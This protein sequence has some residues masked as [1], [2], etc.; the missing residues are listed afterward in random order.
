MARSL[1]IAAYL[2]NLGATEQQAT[3]PE[4]APRPEGHIIW[5][6]CCDPDQLTAVETLARKLTV[7][8]D[9][10]H[11]MVT[12]TSW[13]PVYADRAIPEP[14]GKA[15]IADFIAH[16]QPTMCVWVK[17]Q[18]DVNLMAGIQTS[19]LRCMLVDATAEGLEGVSGGWVPGTMRTLLTQFEA[20][21]TVDQAAADKLVRAGAPEQAI[22]VAGA[23]EDCAP[24]MPYIESER[25]ELSQA[26]GT[27]PVW[28]AASV[29]LSEWDDLCTAQNIASLRAHRLLLIIVPED[30]SDAAKMAEKMREFGFK[31][32]L[33]SEE[34]DPQEVTQIYIVDTDEELGLWY[35][36][37]PLTYVGG[38]L[39]GKNCRD[40]FE[41]AVLG[42]AVV[43]GPNV[44]AYQRHA[45]RLNAADAS[46][47]I[48]TGAELGPAI[49]ALMSADK[50][51]QLAHKAW[52]VTSRG[53]NV[54]NRIAA[55][56]Q[57]R[58]EELVH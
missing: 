34:Y 53:A 14:H 55:F 27:R 47:L 49:E 48:R 51:A 28:L 35:R 33:R 40:P 5:A 7:D 43:Y 56:I 9:E 42:S 11:I 10:V 45:A 17:G 57:L 29:P 25:A 4:Y 26:I 31:T 30:P 38:T 1:S 21:L 19:Q 50:A 46:R 12:L 22:I 58:L 52:D 8:D 37:A 20:I 13:D 2:A 23:M 16:W 18:L 44:G 41:A 3:K 36:L 15:A 6:R 39:K 24:S 54:T 32:A